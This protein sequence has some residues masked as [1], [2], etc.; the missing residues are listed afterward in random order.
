ME[1]YRAIPQGYMTV[2]QVA[3]KIG[4]T[5]R[6][7]QYYD[8]ESLFSPSST[9][10]G[11]FRLYTEK[12]MEKLWRILLLRE[13]GYQLN[14]IKEIMDN[15]N[16]DLRNSIEKHIEELTKK[17]G[18]LENLIGYARTIKMMGIIPQNFNEYGDITFDEFIEVSKNSWNMSTFAEKAEEMGIPF[19]Y[20][21]MQS[22]QGLIDEHLNQPEK[23]WNEEA[24]YGMAEEV[25]SVF[26]MDKTLAFQGCIDDFV[27]LIDK[28]VN[29]K[30][31]QGHVK[32]LYDHINNLVG[33][34][35]SINGFSLYA[36]SFALGGDVGMM[37][38]ERLGEET[39]DFITRAIQVYCDNFIAEQNQKKEGKDD[40]R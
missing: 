6:T 22:I 24:I 37:H 5:V 7:L 18:R 12:Q 4:I 9:S 23:S 15:P 36:Q 40:G 29:S 2:G 25:F 30:E 38:T 11:G 13:L 32:K 21:L 39:T 27:N 20:T 14:D 19:D 10:E 17:K 31:V 26:D 16:Y 28:D 1:K 33:R 35:M 8:K 3:K 34:S